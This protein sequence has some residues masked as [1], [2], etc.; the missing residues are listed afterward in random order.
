[1]GTASASGAGKESGFGRAGGAIAP[2]HA[3]RRLGA[4][5]WR[6]VRAALDRGR[7]R[8]VVPFGA[9]EQ[10]DC[11]LP[12]ETDALLGD[13]LG[14]LLATRLDALCAPTVPIGCS[15]HHMGRAGTLS[16]R[17]ETLRLIVR[18]V[19]ESLARHGFRTIVLLPTHA[20]NASP[21]AHAARLLRPPSGVRIVA[22]ADM[23][24]LARAL[25][26]ASDGRGLPLAEAIAHAGEIETSLVLA[27]APAAL[28]ARSDQGG[29]GRDETAR[30]LE[31]VETVSQSGSSDAGRATEAA[32]R[33]YVAAFL[34]ECVRQ[35]EAQGVAPCACA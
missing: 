34:A 27:L 35:L 8:V 3:E 16:L 5:T 4:M 33:S 15:E 14:P 21:L 28:R 29:N 11:H 24:A 25:Y 12:L 30:S 17:P 22:A 32:G 10:H 26:A 20:G 18:D 2:G 6:D 7:D 31:R 23:H 1:M 13:R 19:V 9:V